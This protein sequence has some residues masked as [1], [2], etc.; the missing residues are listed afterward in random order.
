MVCVR[1]GNTTPEGAD[2]CQHCGAIL[3]PMRPVID[4][5]AGTEHYAWMARQA[6]KSS[7]RSLIVRIG[8]GL[9]AATFIIP[10]ILS[11]SP[12]DV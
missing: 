9:V 6:G 4:P 8:L 10:L 7:K 3:D 2:K 12:K 1:C 11:L 5:I